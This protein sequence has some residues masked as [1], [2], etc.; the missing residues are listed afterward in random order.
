MTDPEELAYLLACASMVAGLAGYRH[1]G[2]AAL[3]AGCLGGI[4]LAISAAWLSGGNGPMVVVAGLALAT[5][6]AAAI[7]IGARAGVRGA[8]SSEAK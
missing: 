6:A 4:V 8:R 3:H 7:A 5:V 2:A 1:A